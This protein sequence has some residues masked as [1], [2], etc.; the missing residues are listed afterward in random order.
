[1]IAKKVARSPEIKSNFAA[2]AKYIT[3]DNSD[4]L[5]YMRITNT[6]FDNYKLALREI[7]AT[8]DTNVR[9]KS[10]KTYHLVVSFREGERPTDEQLEDIEKEVCRAIGL[11]DHQRISVLHTDT[12][13]PHLHIAINKV[14]PVSFKNVELIKDHYRLDEAC[15]LL[16]KKHGLERDNRIDRDKIREVKSVSNG[17]MAV[18]NN[19]AETKEKIN[20]K[21]ENIEI[22]GGRKSF[23]GWLEENKEEIKEALDSAENWQDL[24]AAAAAFDLEFRKRG[25]GLVIASR[26]EKAFTKASDLGREFSK[27]KLEEKLGAFEE[28]SEQ[29]AAIEPEKKY[30]KAPLHDGGDQSDLWE[31]YQR[32]KHLLIA[33]K[34][35]EIESLR[36]ERQTLNANLRSNYQASRRKLKLN[37]MI[38]GRAKFGIYKKMAAANKKAREEIANTHREKMRM[39]HKKYKQ[40]Q[41]QEWLIDKATEG[42]EKALALLRSRAG[43]PKGKEKQAFEGEDNAKVFPELHPEIQ[44]NGEVLYTINKTPVRD[45]GSQL[46]LDDTTQEDLIKVLRLAREKYGDHLKI[47]GT[48]N[49][50]KAVV[51]AAAASGQPVTFE[52]AAM[53]KR[54]EL[55]TELKGIEEGAKQKQAVVDE[56]IKDRN[57]TA[58]NANMLKHK[59]FDEKDGGQAVYK[60]SRNL[61]DGVK[62][63]LYSKN[64]V[65]LVV[66]ISDRQAARYRRERVGTEVTLDKRGFAQFAKQK[67][68]GRGI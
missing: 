26:S 18:T 34:N 59:L 42:D 17:G 28:A 56:W 9:A 64:E 54:F 60:G 43:K 52:D 38:S 57:K 61:K 44:K 21:K 29:V 48:D 3:R 63:A 58:Q 49:F 33:E 30:V 2:L 47:E 46:K 6:G 32:E 10:D 35:K 50:K 7:K 67:D 27:G 12:D 13:N 45:T 62:V 41:W 20:A 37:T 55:I 25:S 40:K 19:D 8:Q 22:H 39:V 16:E 14:H 11:G 53:Q 65:M 15:A 66:P 1:M 31:M 4:E 5:E 51:Q 23:A 68:T 36:S 24:Q